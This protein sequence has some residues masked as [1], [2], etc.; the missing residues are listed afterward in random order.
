MNSSSNNMLKERV[1]LQFL[2]SSSNLMVLMIL[3]QLNIK[4]LSATLS[5]NSSRYQ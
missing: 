3:L 4:E 5:Q 1:L 2:I